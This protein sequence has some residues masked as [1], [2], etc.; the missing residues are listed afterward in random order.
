MKESRL[1]KMLASR[2][3]TIYE[4]NRRKNWLK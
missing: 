2:L 3:R 4:N 1:E